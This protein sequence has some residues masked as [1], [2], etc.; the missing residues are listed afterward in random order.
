MRKRFM[1]IYLLLMATF[2]LMG[3]N[4]FT[5]PQRGFHSDQPA[6][7]WEHSLLS[8]NGTMGISVS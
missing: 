2:S 6:I 3:Q 1:I 8:G 5:I 4:K 7:N